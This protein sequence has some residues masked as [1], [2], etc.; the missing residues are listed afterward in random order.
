MPELVK[1][2]SGISLDCP[3]FNT[4]S[5]ESLPVKLVL[6]A[7]SQSKFHPRTLSPEP[8]STVPAAIFTAKEADVVDENVSASKSVFDVSEDDKPS[9]PARSGFLFERGLNDSTETSDW[10]SAVSYTHLTLPTT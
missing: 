2:S 9:P 3:A 5:K 6:V 10:L 8:E 7:N 4:T 1:S